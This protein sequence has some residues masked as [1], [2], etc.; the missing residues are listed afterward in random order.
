MMETLPRTPSLRRRTFLAATGLAVLASAI[1]GAP[2][3]PR[4]D[5]DRPSIGVPGVRGGVV[6]TS[7]PVAAQVGAEVLRRGGN[8]IDAAAAVQFALN[9]LE[10]Q[11]SGIGGG[12]FMMIHLADSRRTF[13][14]D[15]RERAPGAA[16][17]DMFQRTSGAAFPFSIRSTSGIAV[18]VPG[19]VLGVATALD[20]WGTLSLSESLQPAIALARD[21]IRV[22]SRLASSIASGLGTGRLGNEIGD[23][24]YDLAR[25]VFTDG[26]GTGLV[27]GALL[28]QP[29]LA[30][31]FELL[32]SQGP[33][34]FYRGAIAQAIVDTQ[35]NARTD[36]GPSA[37]PVADQARLAGRMTLGDL[38]GYTI[39]VRDPVV[40][41]YRDFKIV[42]MPPPSS[43]GLTV[44]QILKLMERFPIGD[45]SRGFGF[46]SL[47]TL[48]VMIESM[49]LAFADR[50]VWMGDDDFVEVPS[51]G[52]IDDDY[53]AL[54]SALI[55]PDARQA[56]VV[57]D[58]PRPFDGPGA[59][60]AVRPDDDDEDDVEGRNTT[61]FTIVDRRGNI[62]TYTSTIESA[63]GTG[64]MVPGFG[65][66]LNNELTDFNSVPQFD[67]DP[68]NFN[69][70]AN[71]VAA[72]KR[73]RSSMAP[74]MV[75]D[76]RRPLAAYGSPGGSTIIDSV[77]NV[78]L[79]LIDHQKTVQEAVD[80]PRIAQT[81]ANGTTGREAGFSEAAVDGLTALGHRL[82]APGAIGSVQAVVIDPNN[83]KQ[84][85]AA[86]KR[87][88]GGIVSLRRDDDGDDD[89]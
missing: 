80:A 46:G 77:V 87:R 37:D 17:P 10:P 54:R 9:A 55:D 31:A 13:V 1:L 48:N 78:T 2:Q 75:F 27:E 47:R 59:G 29:D 35:L 3:A 56:N 42:S 76:G 6:T 40:G 63:W 45:E 61:H 7:E 60:P 4:A 83:R 22:S 51:R 88:I 73:P 86:D 11:S 82:R 50:A 24:A 33:D 32:A 20:R 5:D 8:A 74:T 36:P 26:G 38:D 52:L 79:N 69:P 70:G 57:A 71:D 23:P 28:V 18:G 44:I 25:S 49:R 39:A 34:A 72:F 19:T 65:F 66:L 89:D 67:P 12:G 15:S 84:F 41:T 62:V 58:D 81:S 14:V 68:A 64:L 85:G 21:G 30:N 16:T 43:G 53:I